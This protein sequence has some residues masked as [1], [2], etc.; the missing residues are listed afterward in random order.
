MNTKID[1]SEL[2]KKDYIPYKIT[3]T[4]GTRSFHMFATHA[5]AV[6]YATMEGDHVV[7]LQKIEYEEG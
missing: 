6:H 7:D 5:D 3:Y 1:S 2:K 4:N